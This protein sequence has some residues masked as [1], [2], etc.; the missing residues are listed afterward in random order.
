LP[1]RDKRASQYA[2]QAVALLQ[3]SAAAGQFRDP[4]MLAHLDRDDDLAFL[5]DRDD[6]KRFRA[7]L[8]PAKP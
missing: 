2:R 6:Y 7:S 3:R 4:A 5:R 1:E 8:T